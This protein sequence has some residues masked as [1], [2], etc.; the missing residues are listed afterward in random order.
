VAI[1]KVQRCG[2]RDC[3]RKT[4]GTQLCRKDANH[5]DASSELQ[6]PMVVVEPV[7]LRQSDPVNFNHFPV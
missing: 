7:S 3:P 2:Q 1:M 6:V 5:Y 4:A